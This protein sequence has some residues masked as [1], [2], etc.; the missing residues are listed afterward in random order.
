[1]FGFAAVVRIQLTKT[2]GDIIRVHLLSMECYSL[3]IVR[4]LSVTAGKS[5]SEVS[6]CMSSVKLSSDR[7]PDRRVRGMGHCSNFLFKT[8]HYNGNVSFIPINDGIITF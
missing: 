8:G 3:R 4:K 7:I 5:S 1:M 6:E 2:S